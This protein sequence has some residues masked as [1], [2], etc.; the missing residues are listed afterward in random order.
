MPVYHVFCYS[1]ADFRQSA[2]FLLCRISIQGKKTCA[3]SNKLHHTCTIVSKT[4]HSTEVCPP[5]RFLRP[6]QTNKNSLIIPIGLYYFHL[7]IWL[8]FYTVVSDCRKN[9]VFVFPVH[10]STT[11]H[12]FARRLCFRDFYILTSS[13]FALII[14]N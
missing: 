3:T 1:S 11:R 4:A 6:L 2:L 12:N 13:Q 14:S 10:T 8:R 5:L 9:L 7:Y